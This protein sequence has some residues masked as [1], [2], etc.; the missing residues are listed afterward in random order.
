MYDDDLNLA[1]RL[2]DGDEKAF[3]AFFDA[4]YDRVYRFCLRRLTR[5][6][7]EDAALEA[8]RQAIRRI[9]TYRGEA[10]LV[11]WLFQVARSQ[12]SALY[13]RERKHRSLVLLE[14]DPAVQQE[15][16]QMAEQ[17]AE[18]PEAAQESQRH[19]ELVHFLLDSLPGN[20]GQVLQWKY[21]DGYSVDEI[22]S[23]LDASP[24]SIQSM[25]ARARKAFRGAYGN[26]GGL[27][28]IG[29]SDASGG[30]AGL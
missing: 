24:T 20:Y 13:R 23:R 21:M 6:D 10:L 14:D 16:E 7:A 17:L 4:Y 25:L 22:A 9:E 8:M 18:N 3:D 12:I 27:D 15:V 30:M 1:R 19:R 26:V 2:L 29:T 5:Q 28:S 11:T